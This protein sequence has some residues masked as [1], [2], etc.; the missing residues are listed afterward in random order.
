MLKQINYSSINGLDDNQ[1]LPN[2]TLV[3]NS[4]E[5]LRIHDGT[6]PGG[7][8]I[9]SGA[10]FSGTNQL[11]NSSYDVILDSNGILNLSTASTI[12]GTGTD[13]NVYIE[14]L[15]TA[16]TS[17]W[18]F[19]IDGVL[20]LPTETPVIQGAGTGT[21]VTVIATTG[22]NTAT[23]TFG[24]E[25]NLALPNGSSIDA[26]VVGLGIGL[27]TD[28]GTIRFGNS[29]EPG[30]P[31]HYH[32]MR[33]PDA[34]LDLYFGD[35]Y[36]YVL[37]P[38]IGGL[39]IGANIRSGTGTQ[40]V[41]TFDHNGNLT[42]PDSSTQSTAYTRTG[43]APITAWGTTVA[44]DTLVFGFDGTTGIPGFNG[45]YGQ[46][47]GAYNTLLW[48]VEVYQQAA[49]STSIITTGGPAQYFNY[50]APQSLT[51][52]SLQPGDYAIMRI[53]DLD[54]NRVYR[55]TFMGSYNSVST[56]TENKFGSIIVERLI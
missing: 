49:T 38:T 9:S 12:L 50:N 31:N 24:A 56:G 16:T 13:P 26:G 19:G 39:A 52:S 7:N 40:Q 34:Y 5:Q 15:T 46:G 32:I 30:G 17:V 33:D 3:I 25:G 29:P 23:W 27:T 42:F 10:T 37:Q 6:T 53:Q 45:G 2:G 48:S 22:T 55:T 1:I 35:D 11:V 41:W 28:R 44:F 36:N 20:T 47:S 4:S 54:T 21:D 51:A 43:L 14:T 18:T 8:P